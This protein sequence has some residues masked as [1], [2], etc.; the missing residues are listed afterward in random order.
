MSIESSRKAAETR[1]CNLTHGQ[2]MNLGRDKEVTAKTF[3]VFFVNVKEGAQ[4]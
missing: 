2:E 3:Q 4:L 1:L